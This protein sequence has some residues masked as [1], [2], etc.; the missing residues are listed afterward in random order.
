M[1][2][3]ASAV[4]ALVVESRA[5]ESV[6]ASWD[7]LKSLV[8][9]WEGRYREGFAAKVS[10]RL[11]SNGTVVM[12]TLESAHDDQMVTLYHP[13]GSSLL[14]THYCSL[15]NQTRMRSR[16]LEGGRLVFAYVDASNVKSKDD[17][18]MSGLV[19]TFPGPD[20][21]IHEWTSREGAREQTGRFEFAR[22]K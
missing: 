12:E 16:G 2:L 5:A 19:M 15:G 13:D 21:L 22:K 20:R 1:V 3:A 4:V 18:V 6:D 10:Y 17:L 9:D 11:V 8:G 7:R 14:L